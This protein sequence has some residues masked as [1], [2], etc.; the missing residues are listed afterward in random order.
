VPPTPEQVEEG[1]QQSLLTESTEIYVAE[2]IAIDPADSIVPFVRFQPIE[3]F[4]RTEAETFETDGD[5][6]INTCGTL[7]NSGWYQGM[8]VGDRVL[9]FIGSPFDTPRVQ[10]VEP[11]TTP[12]ANAVIETIRAEAQ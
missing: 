8:G 1:F 3:W 4:R 2:V 7:I 5:L 12:R 11:L 9:V 10:H 6:V